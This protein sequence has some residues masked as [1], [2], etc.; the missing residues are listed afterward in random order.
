MLPTWATI[1]VWSLN[2]S[3]I[4]ILKIELEIKIQVD[5][6]FVECVELSETQKELQQ[7]ARKVGREEVL[8]KAGKDLFGNLNH[9]PITFNRAFNHFNLNVFYYSLCVFLSQRSMTEPWNFLG[10]L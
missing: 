6:R 4:M 8:P 2:G 3:T 5:E 9:I 1:S 7:L 10:P